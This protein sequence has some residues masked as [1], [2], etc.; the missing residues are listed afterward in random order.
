MKNIFKDFP[1]DFEKTLIKLVQAG[2]LENIDFV[3]DILRNYEGEPF[4]KEIC[5]EIVKH[6]PE[7][8]RKR[9][10]SVASVLDSTGVV[11]GEFGFVEA[12]QKRY[13][14]IEDWLQDPDPKVRNFAERYRANLSNMIEQE[15]KSAEEKIELRKHKYGKE[16]K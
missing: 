15:R 13:D 1:S 2:K 14:Q 6:L 11:M 3:V 7:G 12:W 16:N 10:G 9:I 5:R 4:L 8:D